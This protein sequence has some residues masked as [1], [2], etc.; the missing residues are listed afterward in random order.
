MKIE[1]GKTYYIE[2]RARGIVFFPSGKYYTH[3]EEI[4]G[5]LDGSTLL[6]VEN[7]IDVVTIK[8]VK[9][10]RE[11]KPRVKEEAIVEVQQPKPL[12]EDIKEQEFEDML[13][14]E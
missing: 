1:K 12:V 5:N 3:G 6:M 2:A 9:E 10:A 4:N 13:K 8:E 11:S 7:A 14:E